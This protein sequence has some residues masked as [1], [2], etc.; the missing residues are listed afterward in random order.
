MCVCVHR[1]VCVCI[2]SSTPVAHAERE[3]A[4]LLAETPFHCF[5]MCL[6]CFGIQAYH[7]ANR[8]SNRQFK[9]HVFSRLYLWYMLLC[10]PLY[11]LMLSCDLLIHKQQMVAR[12]SA[13]CNGWTTLTILIW[14]GIFTLSQS[15][16]MSLNRVKLPRRK[17]QQQQAR[18]RHFQPRA[19]PL[20]ATAPLVLLL[21]GEITDGGERCCFLFTQVLC[22]PSFLSLLCPPVPSSALPAAQ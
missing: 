14:C 9:T 6:A 3:M 19:N 5:V 20:L 15:I 17:R 12:F 18:K 8:Q 2:F 22:Y 21:S 11:V 16:W 13:K 7:L 4:Y 1:C 10:W